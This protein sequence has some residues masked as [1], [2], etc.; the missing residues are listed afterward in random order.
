MSQKVNSSSLLGGVQVKKLRAIIEFFFS[1][2]LT[3]SQSAN[4]VGFFN[5]WNIYLSIYLHHYCTSL[6]I[7][8]VAFDWPA[9]FPFG[10]CCLVSSLQPDWCF[11][12]QIILYNS[13]VQKTISQSTWFG[14]C[15]HSDLIFYL[16]LDH[17]PLV[18]LA[19]MLS[20]NDTRHTWPQGLCIWCALILPCFSLRHLYVSCLHFTLIPDKISHLQGQRELPWLSKPY[21]IQNSLQLFLLSPLP[22]LLFFIELITT[23]GVCV[24]VCVC[25]QEQYLENNKM[26]V[27]I[28]WISKIAL[29]KNIF[30]LNFKMVSLGKTHLPISCGV[31]CD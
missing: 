29:L 13:F 3:S 1:C 23:W 30:L 4:S 6:F 2:T 17:W 20:F 15:Y 28:C 16:H 24:C 21:L 9:C 19:F 7:V 10:S 11:S 18:T 25:M 12:M 22:V 14:S 8:A 26:L 27:N 31:Q 5:L